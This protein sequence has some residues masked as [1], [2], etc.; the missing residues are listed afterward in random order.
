MKLIRLTHLDLI[1]MRNLN[2]DPTCTSKPWER[3]GDRYCQ[4]DAAPQ[5][6]I[7][8][9]PIRLFQS[10]EGALP[11]PWLTVRFGKESR[12]P[13]LLSSD[14]CPSASPSRLGPEDR[15]E[16]LEAGLMS[17]LVYAGSSQFIA[18]EMISKGTMWLPI[19][20]TT[21]FVN[22]RHF[23]MSSTI[24]HLLNRQPLRTLIFLSAQL[25]DE[26]F[27]VATSSRQKWRIGQDI[28]L[29]CK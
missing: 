2:I 5:R 11:R 15:V 18:V 17:L 8:H 24:F 28:C 14:T 23:L 4:D 20:I 25:T 26:S 1:Q 27:A 12:R 7:S 10:N 13:F 3:E 16:P 19:V 21:F 29:D 9:S 22:L 6:R